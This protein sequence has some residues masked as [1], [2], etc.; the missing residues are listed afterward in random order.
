[1]DDVWP[2]F[3][4][5]KRVGETELESLP[6]N[7]AAKDLVKSISIFRLADDDVFE[8]GVLHPSGVLR[9]D[10]GLE[11][12][13]LVIHSLDEELVNEPLLFLGGWVLEERIGARSISGNLVPLATVKQLLLLRKQSDKRWGS[14]TFSSFR[15]PAA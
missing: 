4:I 7:K 1:M 14:T 15:N 3:G 9:E 8:F 10:P 12:Q 13:G 6:H 5:D 11:G 2:L